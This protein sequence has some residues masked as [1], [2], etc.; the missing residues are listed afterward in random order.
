VDPRVRKDFIGKEPDEDF[1]CKGVLRKGSMLKKRLLASGISNSCSV[2]NLGPIWNGIPLSLQVDHIDGDPCNNLKDNLRI[3]CPNCHTQTSTYG[4]KNSKAHKGRNTLLKNPQKISEE[5]KQKVKKEAKKKL[6]INCGSSL[7][8]G[9]TLCKTC[10]YI[11]S[12]KVVRPGKEK[13]E[14][15]LK[16][17]YSFSTVGKLFGVSDNAVRKWCKQLGMDTKAMGRAAIHNSTL[18]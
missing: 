12:R 13:L 2:C 7:S 5:P 11:K 1:F 8:R 9:K 18:G 16:G 17:N 15:L 4:H 6:C 14:E 3:I 10:S